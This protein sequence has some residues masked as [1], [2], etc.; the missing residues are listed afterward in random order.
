[1]R[2]IKK[3]QPEKIE[4][5]EGIKITDKSHNENKNTDE[6]KKKCC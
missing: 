2:D 3:N 1:M 6:H 5:G 4:K